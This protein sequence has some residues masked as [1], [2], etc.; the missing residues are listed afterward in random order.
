VGGGS[1]DPMFCSKDASTTFHKLTWLGSVD[2]KP[3][4][5]VMVYASISRGYRAGGYSI[6]AASTV[7]PTQSALDAAFTPFKPEVVDNYEVGFKSDLIHHRLRV[8]GSF[9]YQNYKN[10]QAQIRDFVNN[11]VITLIRNAASA[12]PYGAEL[13]VT[14]QVTSQ[15]IVNASAGY[16]HA[17]YDKYFAR[18]SAGNLL[19]LSNLAFPAPKFTANFGTTYTIPVGPGS[20]KLNAN[21]A[22]LSKVN[23][24]PGPAQDDASLTQPKY[25]LVD[26]RI[27]Y[28]FDDLGLDFAVF[29]KNLTNKRYLNASTNLQSLGFNVGFPGDPRVFGV[30]ARKT[31]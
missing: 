14:G 28:H 11:T 4:S 27:S 3:V 10:I 15:W 5:Q 25:A 7:Y 29:G 23:F 19:D 13:E 26:A 31:F 20:L 17:S 18:D 9:Y 30:Q 22:Y 6:Q 1:I 24:R 8:N 2:W 21:L 16:L 12:K